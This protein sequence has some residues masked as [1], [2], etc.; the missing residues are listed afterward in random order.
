MEK[1]SGRD[2]AL[3]EYEKINED[4]SAAS[5]GHDKPFCAKTII[6]NI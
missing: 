4:V 2:Q 3:A 5:D 6:D 1:V